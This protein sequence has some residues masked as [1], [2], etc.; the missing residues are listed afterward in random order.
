MGSAHLNL[1]AEHAQPMLFDWVD[2]IVIRGAEKAAGLGDNIYGF[3]TCSLGW[4]SGIC[5]D[6]WLQ[7]AIG[8]RDAA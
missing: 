7:E 6:I 5:T 3:T 4:M 1:G 2:S 8:A